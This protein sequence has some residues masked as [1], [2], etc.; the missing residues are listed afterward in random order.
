MLEQ[1]I[2]VQAQAVTPFLLRGA[3]GLHE[4]GPEFVPKH[5]SQEGELS[6][7][8]KAAPFSSS[9]CCQQIYFC[10]YLAGNDGLSWES[11]LESKAFW[12]KT[13][14]PCTEKS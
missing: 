2:Q 1:K 3:H 10:Q 7:G 13:I 5:F 4:E 12:T 8:A 11:S 6:L 14:K 9:P